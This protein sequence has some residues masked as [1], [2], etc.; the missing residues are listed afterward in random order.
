V[1]A[2]SRKDARVSS[3]SSL[4]AL[5][6]AE[7]CVIAMLNAKASPVPVRSTRA[8]GI[9]YT[10]VPGSLFSGSTPHSAAAVVI[11]KRATALIPLTRNRLRALAHPCSN[12]VMMF[13]SADPDACSL[14]PEA[15]Q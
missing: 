2:A 1:T 15:E 7:S 5:I 9:T 4:G 6:D 12:A 8:R 11:C 14:G 10:R 3:P 13:I